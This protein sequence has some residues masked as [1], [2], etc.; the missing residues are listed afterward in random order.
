[1]MH[2]WQPTYTRSFGTWPGGFIE[3]G[4]TVL[5]WIAVA[6]LVVALLKVFR[7]H[8]IKSEFED[9]PDEA[10]NILKKRY[11]KGEIDKKQFEEMKKTIE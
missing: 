11:A 4:V 7:G 8:K 9:N 2:Y 1:M 3:L 5:F 10:L 6:F